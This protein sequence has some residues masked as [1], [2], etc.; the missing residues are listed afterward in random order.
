MGYLIMNF[1][2]GGRKEGNGIN[3][4]QYLLY[5]DTVLGGLFVIVKIRKL[6]LKKL[7]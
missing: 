1:I 7:S 3:I 6:R 4:F 5:I 2:K